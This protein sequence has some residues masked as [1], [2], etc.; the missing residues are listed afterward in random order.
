ML[1][2]WYH[3]TNMTDAQLIASFEDATL[4][5]SD[6]DHSNHVRLGWL[7]IRRDG[8]LGALAAFPAALRRYAI[9]HGKAA[10]YHE[11]ITWPYLI[12]IHE[13]LAGHL[14]EGWLPFTESNRDLFDRSPP[15]L[16]RYYDKEI[17]SSALA[18][19]TFL[20][21]RLPGDRQRCN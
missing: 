3:D 1:V 16:D 5:E 8:L 9:A 15:I 20:L 6:L 18:R 14:N 7:Y 19:T 2:P 11:T 12:L 4:S 10:L 17:L 13:R 21:P